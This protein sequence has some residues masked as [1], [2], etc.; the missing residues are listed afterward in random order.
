MSSANST[1]PVAPKV[2]VSIIFGALYVGTTAAAALWGILCVQYYSYLRDYPKDR[3]LIKNAVLA[4]FSMNTLNQAFWCHTVYT[5][6]VTGF[7]DPTSPLRHPWSLIAGCLL[8]AFIV[9][10]VQV[11]YAWRL[12]LMSHG[13]ILIITAIGVFSL[14][15]FIF[16]IVLFA[17][18][19]PIKNYAILAQD[20]YLRNQL[21]ILD[22]G[23]LACG[24]TCDVIIAGTLVYLLRKSNTGIKRSRLLLFSIRTGFLTSIFAVASVVLR[25]VTD[26][27]ARM[28]FYSILTRLYAN[29]MIAVLN[30]RKSLRPDVQTSSKSY[31]GYERSEIRFNGTQQPALPMHVS[32]IGPERSHQLSIVVEGDSNYKTSTTKEGE[33]SKASS[34]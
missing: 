29:S 17:R 20:P 21:K 5:Y 25:G 26:E 6:M 31:V 10:L 34:L 15:A 24:A 18:V 8:N 33:I 22:F 13:N 30:E 11:F 19:L 2:D 28:T 9:C 16:N 7:D 1:S 27:I 4:L 32:T 12:W 14:G 3:R 23:F